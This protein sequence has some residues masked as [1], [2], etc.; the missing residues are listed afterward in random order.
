MKLSK[1]NPASAREHLV[2]ALQIVEA[3]AANGRLA[4]AD[5]WMRQDLARRLAGLGD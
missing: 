3:L 4:P 2:S 5:A 1:A